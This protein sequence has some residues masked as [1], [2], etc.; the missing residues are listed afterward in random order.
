LLSILVGATH[1]PVSAKAADVED[2]LPPPVRH[3]EKRSLGED[4]HRRGYPGHGGF[5]AAFSP[6]GKILITGSGFRGVGWWDVSTGR[7]LDTTG[8]LNHDDA[9]SGAFTPDGK[10]VLMTSWGGHHGGIPV[11]LWDAVKR[12]QLRGLDEDVND[13]PFS[14]LAVAPDGKTIALGAAG[15]NRSESFNIVFWDLASGDEVDQVEGLLNVERARQ[16]QRYKA[17]AY[18]PDGRTLAVLLEGRALLIEIATRKVRDTMTF[19]TTKEGQTNRHAATGGALAFSPDGRTLAAGCSDGAIRRFDLRSGRELTPLSGHGSPVI[20][21]C[22]MRTG[23]R[24]R[25]YGA[26][27]QLLT[28]RGKPASEWRPKVGS[29]SDDA[30]Q[31]LWD[32]MRGDDPLDLYGCLQTLTANPAQAVP[33]LRKR[34]SPVPKA[35]EERIERLVLDLHKGDYNTRKRAVVALRKLGA[36]VAPALRRAQEKGVYDELLRR[37]YFEFESLAPKPE[38]LRAVRALRVLEQIGSAESAKLLKELAGG[39]AEAALTRQAKAALERLPKADATKPQLAPAALWEALASEDSAV[40]YRAVRALSNRPSA[41]KLLRDRLKEV[42]AK[43]AFDDDPKRVAKLIADLDSDDF[44][45]R[46]QAS[47]ALNDLGPVIVS[48]L[49][50][51]LMEKVSIEVKKRLEKLLADARKGSSPQILR[52]GRALEALELMDGSEPRQTLEVLVKD[53]KVSWVRQAASES[54]KRQAEAKR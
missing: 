34:L 23:K 3:T 15:G 43:G 24:L 30:L 26:D 9:L 31:E 11:T 47:K 1:V 12:R 29:L 37:L 20:A 42:V 18:A 46:Q 25:S 32:V 53:V 33:F 21:L 35:D 7:A 13:T 17:L 45:V 2:L 39:A 19:T 52:I 8:Q 6:D 44:P 54:L 48:A 16:G 49:R 51:A 41:A 40:A 4:D 14:A 38:Q 10:K 50:Q 28:W 27:N 22:W 5:G 36:A